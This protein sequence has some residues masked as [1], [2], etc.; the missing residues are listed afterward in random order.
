MKIIELNLKHENFYCPVSGMCLQDETMGYADEAP[1]VVGFWIGEVVEEPV[2]KNAKLEAAW[3][4]FHR[5]DRLSFQL[6]TFLSKY[7]ND[8]WVVFELTTSGIACG[9]LSSTIWY[10]IDMSW[11]ESE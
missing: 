10:V 2:I 4:V 6:T 11:E 7:Q 3:E 9:P 5:N 1:S 8:D